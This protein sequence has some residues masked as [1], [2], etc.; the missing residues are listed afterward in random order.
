MQPSQRGV[1]TA[2]CSESATVSRRPAL[3]RGLQVA[4]EE[5]WQA[6]DLNSLSPWGVSISLWHLFERADCRKH[7]RPH[8]YSLACDLVE[9][10]KPPPKQ[11]E[12]VETGAGAT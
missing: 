8:R 12:G 1:K 4:R 3:I 2:R 11:G 7:R 10:V 5:V 9:P 6:W